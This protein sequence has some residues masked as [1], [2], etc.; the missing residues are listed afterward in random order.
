MNYCMNKLKSYTLVIFSLIIVGCSHTF[1]HYD[2]VCVGLPKT[3]PKFIPHTENVDIVVVLG[4]GGAR[5]VAHLGVLEEFEKA[6]IPIDLIIGCSAGSLVGALYADQPDA[7][8]CESV[9]IPLKT[10][11]MLEINIFK[12]CYGLSEGGKLKNFLMNHFGNRKFEDLQIPFIAVSTDLRTGELVTFGSGHIAPAVHAS[13]AFPLVFCPLRVYNR[14]L[15]DGGVVDPIPV[16]VARQFNPKIVVAVD[17][18]ELLPQRI[19]KNLLGIATR[20]AEIKFLAQSESCLLDADVIIRPAV[21][22]IGTFD[23]TH[24]TALYEAGKAAAREAIPKI[25][26]ALLEKRNGEAPESIAEVSLK[27]PK[28]TLEPEEEVAID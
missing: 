19:P 5:G 6:N 15:V 28:V 21:G 3:Q 2:D 26:K 27:P 20:C 17:L 10:H 1:Q 13:C 23:D 18:S 22:N 11:D 14:I 24:T 9:M 4:A 8:F 25:K 16:R 12:T 7:L